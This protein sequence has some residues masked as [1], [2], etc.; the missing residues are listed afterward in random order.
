MLP[1]AGGRLCEPRP[2]GSAAAGELC[3]RLLEC[4]QVLL[5][6]VVGLPVPLV[7]APKALR[8][9]AATELP[10]ARLR[11][12]ELGK[13]LL[14]GLREVVVDPKH[15]EAQVARPALER[16]LVLVHRLRAP[17]VLEPVLVDT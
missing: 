1:Y 17:G 16:L 4:R 3:E 9:Q 12:R 10:A 6:H 8:V 14:L 15:V 5:D 11:A 13:R 2:G 7:P